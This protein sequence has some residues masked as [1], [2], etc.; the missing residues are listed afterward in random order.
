MSDEEHV[1]EASASST[2]KDEPD[3]DMLVKLELPTEQSTSISKIPVSVG[4]GIGCWY[5]NEYLRLGKKLDATETQVKSLSSRITEL[6]S[7]NQSNENTI[8]LLIELLEAQRTSLEAKEMKLPKLEQ[9]LDVTETQQISDP[10]V[11]VESLSSGITELRTFKNKFGPPRRGSKFRVFLSQMILLTNLNENRFTE[12]GAKTGCH[13]NS[14][15][16]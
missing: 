10:N 2:N 3:M 8:S 14:T 5:N 11:K 6:N 16:Q 1:T 12:V 15:D 13:R 9:K 7:R 4:P